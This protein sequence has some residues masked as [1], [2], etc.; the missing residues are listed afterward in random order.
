MKIGILQNYMN[1]NKKQSVYGADVIISEMFEALIT[2]EKVSKVQLTTLSNTYEDIYLRRKIKRI[3]NSNKL[4]A[5]KVE[6]IDRMKLIQEDKKT[7][8]D[9]LHD[10]GNNFMHGLYYRNKFLKE[11]VP[12]T[13]TLHCSSMPNYVRDFYFQQV[14]MPFKSYDSLICTSSSL[15]SVVSTYIDTISEKISRYGN[16]K[17]KYE[18]RMDI[19]PLG[20]DT[21]KFYPLNKKEV[22]K[23]YNID[24]DAFVILC[25]GR[26]SAFDKGDL[27]PVF[28]VL[29][30]IIVGN[31]DTNIIL[32][33][34]GEDVSGIQIKSSYKKY[35]EELGVIKNIIFTEM[36]YSER[37]EIYNMAD[38]FLAP[39]DNIQETFGLTPI[40]AMAAGIPQVVSDWD[41][42]KDTVRDGVTGFRIPTYMSLCDEDCND[43]PYHLVENELFYTHFLFAQSTVIDLEILQDKI[44]LLMKHKYLRDKM[45]EKSI[46]IANEY[47]TLKNMM[48]KYNDLWSELIEI[49]KIEDGQEAGK[50]DNVMFDIYANLYSDAYKSYPT[51]IISETQ[52][53]CIT[54]YGI[55]VMNKEVVIPYHYKIEEIFREFMV[56][57]YILELVYEQECITI[58]QLIDNMSSK[59]NKSVIKRGVMYLVKQGALKFIGKD[60]EII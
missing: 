49:K 15:K 30:R 13:F 27:Y 2:S 7:N 20:I 41:G 47:F 18:G 5:D 58:G 59:Y 39:T 37:N 57:D 45:S 6:I 8:V 22:R 46:E 23:K 14:I 4:P 36:K 50:K 44:E 16:N 1:F 54:K 53:M 35:A 48:D 29:K 17:V 25:A 40:E 56:M 21:N 24:S 33:I 31:V 19:I 55:A 52:M 11:S 12:F 32:I 28:L 43:F 42:Y 60:F 34:A 51:Y 38:V 26:L 9:I 10:F 3:I